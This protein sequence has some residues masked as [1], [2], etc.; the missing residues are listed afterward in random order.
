[1]RK[2]YLF[3]MMSL[4]GYFEGPNHDLSW[5]NAKNEEFKRL[6]AEHII[7]TDTIVM[8]HMTYDLMASFW[9]TEQAKKEDPETAEFMNETKKYVIAHKAFDPG[10]KNVA[11]ITENVVER[12]RELKNMEGKNI[13]I[14]GSNNLCLN[15]MEA[16]LV[17][18][19]RIMVNPVVL[20]QGTQLFKLIRNKVNLELIDARRYKS[21]NVLL[22]YRP[23][24]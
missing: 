23:N 14:L 20:G 19:L 16:G 3:M 13:V 6:E 5:H 24:R 10:W 9:P 15:L 2:L 1:M 18:E 4:D 8:G 7:E 22:C 17:D 21:G 12:I 11:V